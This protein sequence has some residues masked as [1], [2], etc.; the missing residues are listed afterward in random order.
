MELI[1][2]KLR[3]ETAMLPTLSSKMVKTVKL[4]SNYN[5]KTQ[6]EASQVTITN[7]DGTKNEFVVKNGRDGVDGRT[8]T[9]SVRDNGDEVIQSLLQI[10]KV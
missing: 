2:L 10:Q 7:P 1:L 3:M 4:N 8:P 6:M 9:A 5:S